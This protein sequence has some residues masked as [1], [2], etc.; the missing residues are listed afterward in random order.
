MHVQH[1]T[2]LIKAIQAMYIISVM[3]N[4][5]AP[6]LHIMVSEGSALTDKEKKPFP[7]G[8]V[9]CGIAGCIIVLF[10]TFGVLLYRRK[11]I[12]CL[13]S[14][15]NVPNS[16][17]E[18]TTVRETNDRPYTN[19]ELSPDTKHDKSENGQFMGYTR[20]TYENSPY[21]GST[22]PKKYYVSDLKQNVDYKQ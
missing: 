9:A 8:A 11:H 7:S 10:V 3:D 22:C 20:Q 12:G 2:T 16:T 21:D 19:I 15:R 18:S 14:K 1:I 4:T 5:P 13:Q 17:Y 6:F